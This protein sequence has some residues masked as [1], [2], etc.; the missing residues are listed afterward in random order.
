MRAGDY[1]DHGL[2]SY[3]QWFITVRAINMFNRL[4]ILHLYD[5][6]FNFVHKKKYTRKPQKREEFTYKKF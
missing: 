2:S 4:N 3:Q 6:V 5:G 1:S